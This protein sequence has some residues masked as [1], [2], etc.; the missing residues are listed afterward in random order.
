MRLK[1]A[2]SA[3][4]PS[5]R[6][7]PASEPTKF[8]APP[9]GEYEVQSL[10]FSLCENLNKD[11]FAMKFPIHLE[12][13]DRTSP[14]HCFSNVKARRKEFLRE[15]G[16]SRS[17]S[18]ESIAGG[19]RTTNTSALRREQ[20]AVSASLKPHSCGAS[21]RDKKLPAGGTQ[22][23]GGQGYRLKLNG[24]ISPYTTGFTGIANIPKTFSPPVRRFSGPAG[25]G[26]SPGRRGR[27][28]LWRRCGRASAAGSSPSAY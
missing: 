12:C 7:L 6:I 21:W 1:E 11:L 13:F 26:R 17:E 27:P 20:A 8:S 28:A 23:T 16:A 25:P 24:S 18:N 10:R 19:N 9:S 15:G 3:K 22:P 2:L 5:L 14:K 4:P